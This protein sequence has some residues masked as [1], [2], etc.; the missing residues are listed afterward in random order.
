MNTSRLTAEAVRKFLTGQT[1]DCFHPESGAFAA[2]IE[3][4]A[5]GTCRA[6]MDDGATDDGQYGFE[7]DLY[8]TQ[9][10]WFR[11]GGRFRFWLERIDDTSCQA[12]F[13]DGNMAFLQTLRT[14]ES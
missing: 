6:V 10:S 1:L 5:N 12:Y 9:Y 2:T 4:L 11:G 13:D 3:Y 14:K 8:W 7:E